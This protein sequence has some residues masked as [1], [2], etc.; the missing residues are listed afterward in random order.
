MIFLGRAGVGGTPA[1]PPEHMSEQVRLQEY[2]K[3]PIWSVKWEL[4]ERWMK[5]VISSA[6]FVGLT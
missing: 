4:M 1:F 5:T 3:K 2:L 6:D